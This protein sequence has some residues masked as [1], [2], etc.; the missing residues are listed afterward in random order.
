MVHSTAI[1]ATMITISER[2][3]YT[4]VAP[5]GV[6]APNGVHLYVT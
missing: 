6:K 5:R 2:I 3:D 1:A 4:Q